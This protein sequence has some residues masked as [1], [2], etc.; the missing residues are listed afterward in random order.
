V[1]F[2]MDFRLHGLIRAAREC[3]VGIAMNLRGSIQDEARTGKRL[4]QLLRTRPKGIVRTIMA[5]L[6]AK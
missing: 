2:W 4:S 3:A 1:I 5:A 6:E